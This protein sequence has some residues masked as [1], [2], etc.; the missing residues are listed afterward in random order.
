[1]GVPNENVGFQNPPANVGPLRNTFAPTTPVKEPMELLNA[2]R[3]SLLESEA[4]GPRMLE[5]LDVWPINVMLLGK[6]NTVG[7]DDQE[8]AVAEVVDVAHLAP[9]PGESRQHGFSERHA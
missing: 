5:A 6:G 7:R 2:F 9:T 4:R 8:P 1:M 3:S